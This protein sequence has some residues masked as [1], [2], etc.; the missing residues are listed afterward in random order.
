MRYIYFQDIDYNRARS[1]GSPSIASIKIYRQVY[2][3]TL[4][5]GIL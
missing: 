5:S 1:I 2:I 4:Q 3:E